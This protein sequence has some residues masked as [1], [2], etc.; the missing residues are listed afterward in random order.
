M[1]ASARDRWRIAITQGNLDNNHIYIT[2][3]LKKGA[4]PPDVFGN[5][6]AVR[7]QGKNVTLDVVGVNT[8][9]T[10]VPRARGERK[11][12]K[13]LPRPRSKITFEARRVLGGS[14]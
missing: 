8:V 9:F 5:A 7:G 12:P 3:L 4:I 10:D 14:G 2:E 11:A 1:A 13:V 6:Q